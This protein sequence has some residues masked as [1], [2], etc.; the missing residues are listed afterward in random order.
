MPTKMSSNSE[1]DTKKKGTPASPATARAMRVLPVP[2]GPVKSTPRGAV[3]PKEL[4]AEG[5]WEEREEKKGYAEIVDDD[6]ELFD[7]VFDTDHVAKTGS[8]VGFGLVLWMEG[9]TKGETRLSVEG[10]LV[11]F[12]L[13]IYRTASEGEDQGNTQVN[14]KYRGQ[15]DRPPVSHH[16][17]PGRRNISFEKA[18]QNGGIQNVGKT[19]PSHL[20]QEIEDL[21]WSQS[22]EHVHVN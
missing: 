13:R 11:S 12:F 2:G 14:K 16:D 18:T 5:S 8:D 6:F 20:V 17:F 1:A 19:W 22:V 4:K 21:G 9:E 7:V 3:A 15:D 10:L